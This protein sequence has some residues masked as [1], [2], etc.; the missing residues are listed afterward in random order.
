MSHQ[1]FVFLLVC[2]FFLFLAL[3][4]QQGWLLLRPSYARRRAK[5]SHAHRLLKPGTPLD[6]PACRNTG[7]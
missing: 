1:V 3:L 4:W 6:C 2:F 5:P 7:G